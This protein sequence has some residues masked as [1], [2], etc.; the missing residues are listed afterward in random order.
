[1]N[2]FA[3]RFPEIYRCMLTECGRNRLAVGAGTTLAL[4]A[5]FWSAASWERD[6]GKTLFHYAFWTQVATFIVYGS[7][8]AS[9]SIA[10]EREARTWDLQRLTPLTSGDIAA[11]K[12]LGAPLYAAFLAALLTPWALAGALRSQE[13]GGEVAF[14]YLQFLSSAF[15]ALSLSLLASAYSDVSRGGS[16]TTAGTLIGLGSLYT[17]TPVLAKGPLDVKIV[18]FGA[19]VPYALWMPLATAG[20]GAWAFA[21]AKWRVGRDL[22]EPARFWRFPAF[23]LY[24][25]AFVLGFEKASAYFSL[26]MPVIA[27][28]MAALTEPTKPEAWRRWRAAD[29]RGVFLHRTPAWIAGAGVCLAAAI[30]I[31]FVPGTPGAAPYR[32][33]PL[34]L[35]LYLIRDAAFIQCWRFTKSR[36]PEIPAVV[37]LSLAYLVPSILLSAARG[38]DL[39][40]LFMPLIGRDV[41]AWE[42]VLPG[43]LWA[44]ASLTAL[45]FAARGPTSTSR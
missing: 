32:P 7:T 6:P 29:D 25:M 20:F 4:G 15:L 30:V 31:S 36:R 22:L 2:A 40:Y 21:A 9:A 17:L 45:F 38:R 43:L 14:I 41:S 33:L 37:F 8:R 34:I 13:L 1:M 16:A 26:I 10:D 3:R 18:Y 27:T 11:G 24:L 28:L 35:A 42:N 19:A 44:A 23:L 12:L 39:L 5:A